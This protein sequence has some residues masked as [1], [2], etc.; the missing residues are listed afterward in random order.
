MHWWQKNLCFNLRW[1]NKWP[2]VER[3]NQN[4]SSFSPLF[5][6]GSL[7]IFRFERFD[8]MKIKAI[9]M[10]C[11]LQQKKKKDEKRN[12][13][14]AFMHLLGHVTNV[15]VITSY[16][17]CTYRGVSLLVFFSLAFLRYDF[18]RL[19]VFI[20]CN[21]VQH[22]VEQLFAFY[23]MKETEQQTKK[24]RIYFVSPC[25]D[26]HDEERWFS[27]V[28]FS[29]VRIITEIHWSGH[30]KIVWWSVQ[31]CN[32]DRWCIFNAVCEWNMHVVE[33]ENIH[34]T[35]RNH[36]KIFCSI[37]WTQYLERPWVQNIKKE[38]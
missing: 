9:G 1:I 11:S 4:D 31:V 14:N 18:V 7:F 21:F 3:I 5:A 27:S 28:Q 34:V 36:R 12:K 20:L 38:R 22:I 23:K 35:M 32:S 37:A 2:V 33:R 26:Y 13:A 6:A 16:C 29:L 8:F 15:I 30:H 17:H 10:I 25:I 24:K 19:T